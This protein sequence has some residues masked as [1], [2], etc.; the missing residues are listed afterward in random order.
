LRQAR[1]KDRFSSGFRARPEQ[2]FP[3]DGKRR[4]QQK[5]PI[6]LVMMPAPPIIL[7][8][9]VCFSTR[10]TR[11][12][13]GYMVPD[14]GRNSVAVRTIPIDEYDGIYPSRALIIELDTQGSEVPIPRGMKKL[15]VN[16]AKEIV[17]ICEFWPFG[18][19]R[20]GSSAG[21]LIEMIASDVR[22]TVGRNVKRLADCK[23]VSLK[24]RWQPGWEWIAPT[25]AA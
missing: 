8:A 14:D 24:P 21:E 19:E 4:P 22:L 15:L 1:L 5:L 16:H 9:V 17:L 25:S 10:S 20:N 3:S 6:H 23:R 2:L 13:T 11:A 18:L 12:T 7:L